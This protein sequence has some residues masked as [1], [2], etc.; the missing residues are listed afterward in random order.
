MSG[1]SGEQGPHGGG[2]QHEERFG[3]FYLPSL[4]GV[5]ALSQQLHGR[6]PYG[7]SYLRAHDQ[8][9]TPRTP[10][11]V[12]KGKEIIPLEAEVVDL[13]HARARRLIAIPHGERRRFT[14]TELGRFQALLDGTSAG[15]TELEIGD[16]LSIDRYEF[17]E[18]SLEAR[19]YLGATNQASVMYGAR[20][21]GYVPSIR[22]GEM[23]TPQLTLNRRLHL[24]LAALGFDWNE[25]ADFTDSSPESVKTTRGYIRD[26]LQAESIP[27]AVSNGFEA[28]LFITL[29]EHEIQAGQ[30]H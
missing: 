17:Q 25:A 6:P 5:F 15:M 2:P 29:R 7:E 10:L 28:G 13:I 21:H 24:Y 14:A 23:R 1:T 26:K 8:I 19:A 12:K 11:A 22:P 4:L 16:R 18:T 3:K 20:L 9:N 27:Q 30:V